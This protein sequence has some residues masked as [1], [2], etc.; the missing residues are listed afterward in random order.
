M[1]IFRTGTALAL[2][3]TLLNSCGSDDDKKTAAAADG[4]NPSLAQPIPTTFANTATTKDDMSAGMDS[5][6]QTLMVDLGKEFNFTRNPNTSGTS[7]NQTSGIMSAQLEDAPEE[8]FDP[9]ALV[10]G[11]DCAELLEFAS[12]GY[13]TMEAAFNDLN[14]QILSFES[15]F[16]VPEEMKET[17]EIEEL[18]K[19]GKY[20]FHRRLKAKEGALI[21]MNLEVGAGATADSAIAHFGME[22]L[23][24]EDKVVMDMD[25]KIYGNV[26]DKI[27][28]FEAAISVPE[29][30]DGGSRE[31]AYKIVMQGGDIPTFTANIAGQGRDTAEDAL[32]NVDMNIAF[33][34]TG[35][36]TGRFVLTGSDGTETLNVD[37]NL[38]LANKGCKIK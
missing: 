1:R 24:A 27:M 26:T 30:E 20:A 23:N 3:M 29:N 35:T 7:L 33:S 15:D 22:M 36:N 18:D 5:V 32:E 21:K 16:S 8:E 37:Y 19:E 12:E 4:T 6:E 9:E 38:D 28:S 10:A 31:I 13:A 17:M 25:N 11:D 14:D 2:S 34:K